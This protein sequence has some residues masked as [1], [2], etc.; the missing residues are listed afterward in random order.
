MSPK[1][2][3][4]YWDPTHAGL[5]AGEQ[6]LIDLQTLE[7]RFIET[8]Y[9]TLEVEQSFQL[10][11]LNPAALLTL[12]ET[13]SCQFS[14]PEVFFDLCYPGHYRRQIKAVRVTIPCVTGP[15]TNVGA[16]LTML[17]SQMRA[18]AGD[19]LLTTVPPQR[20]VSIATSRAQNDAGVFELSFHDERYMP[21]EGAGAASTWKLELPASFRP[22]DYQT[23]SDVVLTINY[24]SLADGAL[25]QK[26]EE[27]NAK[28]EGAILKYLTNNSLGRL[29][30][31]R[32]EFPVAYKGLLASPP[33]TPVSFEIQDW[34]LP[35][36]MTASGRTILVTV[37]KLAL[38][39]ATGVDLG[40]VQLTVDGQPAG[41][42]RRTRTRVWWAGCRRWISR[43]PSRYRGST[44]WWST[45]RPAWR[46]MRRRSEIYRRSIGRSWSM[47]CFT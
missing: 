40:G 16:T 21:L 42:S 22:F 26:V 28:A 29:F 46:R 24:T 11:Q 13:G 37:A 44:R 3:M 25:R 43:G 18:K 6:L 27:Q 1:L 2:A 34:H 39:T 47:S 20:T 36:F 5:L 10:T 33:G 31:L 19:A 15:Y 17:D 4:S 30:S 12:R 9:R 7:R 35:A 38:K 32:Q 14:I 23:I 41:G 45:L 8:N